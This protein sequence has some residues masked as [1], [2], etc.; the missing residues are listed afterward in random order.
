MK[1]EPRFKKTAAKSPVLVRH[2]LRSFL[3]ALVK[4][5]I[6]AIGVV[7][8]PG[9]YNTETVESDWNRPTYNITIATEMELAMLQ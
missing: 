1:Q 9:H 5:I 6:V 2:V 8:G 3:L 7:K 4:L